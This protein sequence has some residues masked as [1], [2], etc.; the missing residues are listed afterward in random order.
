MLIDCITERKIAAKEFHI[1]LEKSLEHDKNLFIKELKIGFQMSNP[2]VVSTLAYCDNPLRIY[3][4]YMV[5]DWGNMAGKGTIRNHNLGDFLDVVH[6]AKGSVKYFLNKG[7]F[8]KIVCDV[9]SGLHYLHDEKKIAHRDLKPKNILVSNSGKEHKPIL[10]KITDFT[11]SRA[12]GLETAKKQ[13]TSSTRLDRGTKAFQAPEIISQSYDSSNIDVLKQIDIWAFGMVLFC[14]LNPDKQRPFQIEEEHYV[15]TNRTDFA[16]GEDTLHKSMKECFKQ[17]YKFSVKISDT[18]KILREKL[19]GVD[20]MRVRCLQ[21]H[22]S[23]R[24]TTEQ[25]IRW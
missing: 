6:K 11:E 4:D 24:P 25:L 3:M 20:D 10:C 23:V 21:V 2:H 1:K 17:N 16:R 8:T 22:P 19:P 18:Y 7:L 9:I 15:K 5:Y 14:I 13:G 12:R